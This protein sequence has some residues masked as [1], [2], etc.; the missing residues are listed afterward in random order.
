MATRRTLCR[1]ARSPRPAGQ[2]AMQSHGTEAMTKFKA[3][4]LDD[5]S[6]EAV[7]DEIRRVAGLH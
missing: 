6:D 5:R 4:W 2:C 7:L 3:T 1:G